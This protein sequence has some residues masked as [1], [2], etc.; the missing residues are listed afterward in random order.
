[1]KILNSFQQSNKL[2][3]YIKRNQLQ[4]I[5][6]KRVGCKHVIHCQGIECTRHLQFGLLSKHWPSGPMLSIS[7]NVC[8]SACLF[9][10][11]F[12]FEVPFK[13]PLPAEKSGLTFENFY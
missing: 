12:T 4:N 5:S 13:H 2:N 11:V 6:Y 10:H 7:R 3:Y 1:M 9:V 8:L